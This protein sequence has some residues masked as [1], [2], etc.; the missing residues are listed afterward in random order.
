[1]LGNEVAAAIVADAYYDYAT[2]GYV[3]TSDD[4]AYTRTMSRYFL[5]AAK[6]DHMRIL[7]VGTVS[8]KHPNIDAIAKE[9]ERKRPRAILT[10]IFSPYPQPILAKLRAKGIVTRVYATEG[11]DAEQ[12]LSRYAKPLEQVYYGSYGFARK[13]SQMFRSDYEATF[14]KKTL[15]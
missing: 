7:G 12:L 15:G 13:T 10:P 3:L 11:L 8:L 14:S 5:A 9:I 6:L 2:T 4:V 1:M